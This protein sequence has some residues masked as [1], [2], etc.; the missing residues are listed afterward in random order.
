MTKISE[1]E[2]YSRIDTFAEYGYDYAVA[3]GAI[4]NFENEMDYLAFQ[5]GSSQHFSSTV[6][7]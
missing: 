2:S 3:G 1:F 7:T 6:L 5:A 4:P